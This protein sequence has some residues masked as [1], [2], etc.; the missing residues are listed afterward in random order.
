MDGG[1]QLRTSRVINWQVQQRQIH[2]RFVVYLCTLHS[3]IPILHC[4][5]FYVTVQSL[6]FIGQLLRATTLSHTPSQV[7]SLTAAHLAALL[8]ERSVH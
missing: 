3:Y 8:H 1:V 7:Q 5:C 2:E 4:Q 6:Y